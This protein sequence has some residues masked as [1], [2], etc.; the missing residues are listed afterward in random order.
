MSISLNQDVLEEQIQSE[1]SSSPERDLV[2]QDQE[3]QQLQ[4]ELEQIRKYILLFKKINELFVVLKSEMK[5]R[6]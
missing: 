5:V 2:V 6:R 1:G 4:Q 3:Q